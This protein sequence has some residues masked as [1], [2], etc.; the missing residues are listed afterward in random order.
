MKVLVWEGRIGSHVPKTT[1]SG[2]LSHMDGLDPA[3]CRIFNHKNNARENKY[4]KGYIGREKHHN[5]RLAL[6]KRSMINPHY[7]KEERVTEN[8]PRPRNG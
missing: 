7:M 4:S 5:R 1:Y 6:A 3:A 2:H 8:E